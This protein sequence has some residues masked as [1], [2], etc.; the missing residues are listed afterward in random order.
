M[1]NFFCQIDL[2][3]FK[4]ILFIKRTETFSSRNVIDVW[5]LAHFELKMHKDFMC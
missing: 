2:N 3:I 4:F 5:V 1:F